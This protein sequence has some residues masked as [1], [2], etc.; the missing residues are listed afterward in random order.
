VDHSAE[1]GSDF[2]ELCDSLIEAE[3]VH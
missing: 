3:V 2:G 1:K